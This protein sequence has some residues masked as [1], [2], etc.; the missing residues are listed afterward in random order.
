MTQRASGSGG[1]AVHPV[2]VEQVPPGEGAAIDAMIATLET[3]LTTRYAARGEK[4]L[5]DA[6]PKHHGLVKATFVLDEERPPVLRHGIFAVT[7][8]FGARIRFSNSHP[9]VLHDLCPDIRGFAIKLEDTPA[10]ILDG[11][12]HHD[13]ILTTGEAFFGRDA[14]DFADFPRASESSLATLKYFARPKRLRGGWRLFSAMEQP[15]SPID[16]EYFSQTPYRLG[17]HCVKYQVRPAKPRSTAGDPWYL[18]AGIRQTLGSLLRWTPGARAFSRRLRSFDALAD[19]LAADL[20]AQR[21]ELEFLVQ[22]WPDL[23][24]MPIWAIEDPTR[25]WPWRWEKIATI[26]IEPQAT[27]PGKDAAEPITFNPWR[28]SSDHQPLGSI[29]RA[30]RAIYDRMSRFRNGL[31]GADAHGRGVVSESP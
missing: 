10:A 7:R 3:Q 15:R 23:A 2:P 17:P 21:V 22:R 6:H 20:K 31:N 13:F 12:P 14:V 11:S 25:R 1:G 29:N 24:A 16:V 5:R 27:L 28:V 18:R 26:R 4:V 30:R 19:A 8:S 9:I